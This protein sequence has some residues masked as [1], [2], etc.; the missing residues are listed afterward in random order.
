MQEERGR[1]VENARRYALA[2]RRG[3]EDLRLTKSPQYVQG[4]TQQEQADEDRDDGRFKA[5]V[6]GYMAARGHFLQAFSD[7]RQGGTAR[8]RG[9]APGGRDAD[10]AAAGEPAAPT[11]PTPA[12]P[13][14]DLST[15]SNEEARAFVDQLPGCVP[16]VGTSAACSRLWPNMEPT[17]ANEFRMPS[18]PRATLV[19]VFENVTHRPRRPISSCSPRKLLTQLPGEDQRRRNLSITLVPARDRLVIGNIRVR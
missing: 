10:R 8:G 15:W 14:V 1:V 3:A 6:S 12:E 4:T 11:P 5:A 7:E 18:P 17:W 13:T 19:C 16:R 9:S 2:A